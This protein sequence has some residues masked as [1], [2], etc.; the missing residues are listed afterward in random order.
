MKK[1]FVIFLMFATALSLCACSS[2]NPM[3]DF[4][5]ELIEKYSTGEEYYRDTHNDIRVKDFGT[6]Y[7]KKLY[8]V[9]QL[10]GKLQYIYLY[11]GEKEAEQGLRD[12]ADYMAYLD[13]T[14]HLS[15]ELTEKHNMLSY[16]MIENDDEHLIHVMKTEFTNEN[17]VGSIIFLVQVPSEVEALTDEYNNIDTI[18]ESSDAGNN[19]DD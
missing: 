6:A 3:D 18:I 2:E 19:K 16:P 12:I 1:L 8:D 17:N 9:K 11:D 15:Q 7:E 5:Y 13:S 4:N 10:D 14:F